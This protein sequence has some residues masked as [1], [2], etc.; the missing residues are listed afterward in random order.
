M[1]LI[2]SGLQI[3][4][5]F[6]DMK[7]KSMLKSGDQSLNGMIYNAYKAIHFLY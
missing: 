5:G 7:K 4:Y 1:Y 2:S 3:K 6:Y